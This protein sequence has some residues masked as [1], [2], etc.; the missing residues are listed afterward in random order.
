[1]EDDEATPS[2]PSDS[3]RR[4]RRSYHV[5]SSASPEKYDNMMKCLDKEMEA[6]DHAHDNNLRELFSS[7]R[8]LW[9]L[10]PRVGALEE[11]LYHTS[12]DDGIS[13]ILDKYKSTSSLNLNASPKTY[14]S[15]DNLTNDTTPSR[16]R[17][18]SYSRINY[19]PLSRKSKADRW[20]T[21]SVQDYGKY[22]K[23]SYDPIP[24]TTYSQRKRGGDRWETQ[25]LADYS[26]SRYRPSTSTSS[27]RG[28]KTRGYGR[29]KDDI[30][31]SS[32]RSF[33]G[34]DDDD[35]V[36]RLRSRY[37][38]YA[39]RKK[40]DDW[41]P[42]RYSRRAPID[43][44]LHEPDLTTTYKSARTLA[45]SYLGAGDD[46]DQEEDITLSQYT[47]V[48]LTERAVGRHDAYYG[49]YE[50]TPSP[51]ERDD[52]SVRSYRSDLSSSYEPS[53]TRYGRSS[54]TS[55]EYEPLTR[56]S[57]YSST[58]PSYT[59]SRRYDSTSRRYADNIDTSPTRYSTRSS[60]YRDTSPTR[61]STK[62]YGDDDRLSDTGS[63]GSYTRKTSRYGSNTYT[64]P[65]YG[66][67]TTSGRYA[68][69]YT[70][71]RYGSESYESARA[72]RIK[73]MADEKPRSIYPIYMATPPPDQELEDL[74]KSRYGR[75]LPLRT[76]GSLVK[77]VPRSG[78]Q[79]M[80][81]PSQEEFDRDP[82]GFLF[83]VLNAQA[84][85]LTYCVSKMDK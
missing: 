7:R 85:I 16:G 20:E 41:S 32:V 2:S 49:K 36:M 76:Y 42:P 28:Y 56:T 27:V 74:Q 72:A 1:M 82:M 13:Q 57:T 24:T 19:Q 50:M 55:R 59:P 18:S 58:R 11:R 25:S 37:Q 79:A 65:R 22:G 61:Y 70:A 12:K 80:I 84:K 5:S 47:K 52:A 63:V 33:A 35:A 71:P 31:T 68:T 4:T 77:Y 30:E 15:V 62:S 38:N 44:Y 67:G 8:K 54:Y 39:E 46:D 83:G 43:P 21:A 81:A 75:H 51:S 29:G 10:Y 48:P 3:H 60:K 26:E 64:T 45:K 23:R 34:D 14:S 17:T 53:K 73:R 69:G 40:Y 6:R 9:D 66:S 78:N